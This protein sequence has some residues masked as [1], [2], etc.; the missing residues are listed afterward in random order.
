MYMGVWVY[1]VYGPVI[2]Q[3]EVHMSYHQEHSEA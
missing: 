3:L 2:H 1:S